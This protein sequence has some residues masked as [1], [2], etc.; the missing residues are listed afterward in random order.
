[1]LAIL[2][3]GTEPELAPQPRATDIE[4]LARDVGG[5]PHV[6]VNLAGDLDNLSTAVGTALYRLAQESVTNATRHARDATLVVVDVTDEG[7]RVAMTVRDDGAASPTRRTNTGYGLRS[8]AERTALL[9]GTFQ[10]GPTPD[11]GWAVHAVLP[12]GTT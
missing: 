12:K 6:V 5:R 3:D 4:R 11:R 2:R 7:D 10:A 9:R 1:M 8:M